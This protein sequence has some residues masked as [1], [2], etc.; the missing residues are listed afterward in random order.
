VLVEN[1]GIRPIGA[2]PRADLIEIL[3]EEEAA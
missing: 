1:F 3:G 2:S